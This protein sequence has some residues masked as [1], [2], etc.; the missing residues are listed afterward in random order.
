MTKKHSDPISPDAPP[1]A[2]IAQLVMEKKARLV[3][4]LVELNRRIDDLAFLR[5]E[6]ENQL[7]DCEKDLREYV[8]RV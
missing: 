7:N 4:Q 6:L 3:N 8:V 5:V 1:Q 2:Q